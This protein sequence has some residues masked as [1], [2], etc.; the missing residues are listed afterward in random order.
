MATHGG[1]EV[2]GVSLG[3]DEVVRAPD[4]LGVS[5]LCGLA[6]QDR[7]YAACAVDEGTGIASKRLG[8]GRWKEITD[9]HSIPTNELESKG[10]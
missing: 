3:F 6:G 2:T 1:G 9:L 5:V 8:H 10:N 4:G 7:E